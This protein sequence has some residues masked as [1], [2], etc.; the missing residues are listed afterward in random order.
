M[1]RLRR[2]LGVTQVALAHAMGIGQSAVSN[3]ERRSDPKLSS[4]HRWASALGGT[5]RVTLELHGRSFD[6]GFGPA[7]DERPARPPSRM[8]VIWQ[9]PERSSLRHVGDLL[10]DGHRYRFAYTDSQTRARS[11]FAAFPDTERTYE[12]EVLWPFFN[13]RPAAT[14]GVLL[15]DENRP[16]PLVEL[17]GDTDTAGGRLQ[18]VPAPDLA[19]AG[20]SWTFLV[21]GVS[22]A[23]KGA[24][25]VLEALEPGDVLSLHRDFDYDHPT[26]HARRLK[27][28]GL[29]VGWLPDYALAD[30]DRLEQEGHRFRVEVVRV[31][32]AGGNPHLRLLCSL[33]VEV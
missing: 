17:E 7:V 21:S 6:L 11:A 18:L 4:L 12:S 1:T 26:T 33:V 14:L 28:D 24:D 27:R 2:A 29:T 19:S 3:L 31:Q 22:H 20:D 8:R 15:G 16:L 13:D 25:E 30:V 5:L 23:D 10:D 32:P 9:D